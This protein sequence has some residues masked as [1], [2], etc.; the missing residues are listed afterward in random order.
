M[1][2]LLVVSAVAA[3]GLSAVA[4]AGGLPEEMPA[5]PAA[6]SSDTGIYVGIAG[7]YGL[8]NWKNFDVSPNQAG[9]LDNTSKIASV[10][11]DNGF[12]GRAFLGYD[13]CKFFAGEFGYGYFFNKA[14]VAN[15][16]STAYTQYKTQVF[17]LFAKGKLPVTEEFNFFAKLG[18]NYILSNASDTDGGFNISQNYGSTKSPKTFNVAYGAGADYAITP[19]VIANVEWLRYNGSAKLDE[20]YQP[21]LDAFMIG[22]RY[23]FDM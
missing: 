3:L 12:V 17:D 2:K 5:A 6:S 7:G 16:D 20:N 9:L 1:K 18:M 21:N 19:N 11:K 4:F 8:T 10:S 23:K 13:F 22:L 15:P 14:K